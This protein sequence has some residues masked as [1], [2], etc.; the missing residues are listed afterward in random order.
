MSHLDQPPLPD[1]APT[2]VLAYKVIPAVAVIRIP[3][4]NAAIFMGKERDVGSVEEGKLADL[5][6]LAADPLVDIRN[7]ERIDLVIK[8]GTVV[9]RGALDLPVSRRQ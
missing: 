4:L 9:D 7:T 8:G 1:G 3:T 2:R 6:P 5:V